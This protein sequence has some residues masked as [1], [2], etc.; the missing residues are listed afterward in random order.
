MPDTPADTPADVHG[1]DV[2]AARRRFERAAASAPGTD[3]L[4]RE[5]ER[6]MAERL[7]LVRI[8]PRRILD[9]G[10]GTGGCCAVLRKRYPEALVVGVDSAQAVLALD[11][12]GSLAARAWRRIAGTGRA[13]VC[14]D[15]AALPFAGACFSLAWS[16]L[17]LPWTP[18][19][20]SAFAELRRVLERGGLLMFSSYGPD[21]LKELRAA[22]AAADAHSHV[23]RFIDMHDLGDMLVASGFE[24]P[25]MDMEL[26]TLTYADFDSLARDLRLSGQSNVAV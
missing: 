15:L 4:A 18:D 14:A 16:N 20:M 12:P 13:S 3:A 11:A 2:R 23:H 21:T 1:I 19:P 25:V 9:A 8:E 24:T 5:V 26:L 10:C 7:D 17:A 22:F 6:R